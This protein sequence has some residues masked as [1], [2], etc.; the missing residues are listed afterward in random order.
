MHILHRKGSTME[1]VTYEQ[2]LNDPMRICF[3]L[4]SLFT[5]LQHH[6]S[7][8]HAVD[9]QIAMQSLLEVINVIERPDLKS[10]LTQVLT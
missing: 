8:E 5:K 6:M 7:S 3:R 4:E 10:K 1:S 9:H 2:P